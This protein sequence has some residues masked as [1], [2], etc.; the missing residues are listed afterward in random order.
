MLPVAPEELIPAVEPISKAPLL[1]SKVP[2]PV[3]TLLP[4][5]NVPPLPIISFEPTLISSEV[6]FI[7]DAVLVAVTVC[8]LPTIIVALLVFVGFSLAAAPVWLILDQVL[9][10]DQSPVCRL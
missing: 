6:C 1:T 10:F 7:M 5:L 9:L 8:P 3:T 4:V 2:A